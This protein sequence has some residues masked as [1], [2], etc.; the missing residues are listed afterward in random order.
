LVVAGDVDLDLLKL[1]DVW[2][3][4]SSRAARSGTLLVDL[5]PQP[6][7]AKGVSRTLVIGAW[8]VERITAGARLGLEVAR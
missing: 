8:Y 5:L 1:T 4:G 6:A 7:A 3:R 2:R